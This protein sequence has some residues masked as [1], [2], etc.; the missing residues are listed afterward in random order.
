MIF[1]KIECVLNSLVCYKNF[2]KYLGSEM[3]DFS[4][5]IMFS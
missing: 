1:T 5:K 4:T 3:R 2:I